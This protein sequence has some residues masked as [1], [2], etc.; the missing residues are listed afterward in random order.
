MSK[1]PIF[2][3]VHNQYDCLKRAVM[4]YE[5]QINRDIDIIFHNVDSHYYETLEYLKEKEKNGYKVYHSNVNNH[6]LVMNSVRD[7]LSHHPECEYCIITDPDIELWNVRGDILDVYIHML[8]TLKKTTV[9][10]MLEIHNIPDFYHLKK[11]AIKGHTEQFWSKEVQRLSYKDSIIK[12]INCMTDTTFQLFAVKNIP[13]RFPHDNSI[14]LLAPYS[15]LHLDWYI[16]PNHLTPCQLYCHMNSTNISHWNSQTWKGEY[17]GVKI[18][19]L[20]SHIT[21]KRRY[22]FQD[23]V[24][25]GEFGDGVGITKYIYEKLIGKAPILYKGDVSITEE[26]VMGTGSTLQHVEQN[27][28]VWGTGCMTD[29]EIVRTP[30]QIVSVRGPLTRKQIQKNGI[31]CPELYGDI[32]LIM[33]YFFHPKISKKYKIGLIP[34]TSDITQLNKIGHPSDVHIIDITQSIESFII[35]LLHCEYIISSSLYGI[36]LS[37]AYSIPCAWVKFTDNIKEERFVFADYYGSIKVEPYTMITP[38][39]Y[40][41]KNAHEWVNSVNTYPQPVFPLSTKHILEC[42]PFVDIA[43]VK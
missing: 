12:Y 25:N 16:N 17:R 30:K 2:I 7:Y 10:P 34:H 19:S 42:C 3:I 22:V 9:G 4:S 40:E 20:T 37:H 23:V 29:E 43:K 1:I 24:S 15:A 39:Q 33:P 28:I 26:V 8:H 38:L 27:T 21:P 32:G 35:Q 14:R 11:Q 18:N 41:S 36:I 13:T 5:S 6:H 31:T